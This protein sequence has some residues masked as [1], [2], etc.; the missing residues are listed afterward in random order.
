MGIEIDCKGP[1]L[2]DGVT[3]S[4]IGG[5][6][7]LYSAPFSIRHFRTVGVHLISAGGA[8]QDR[9]GNI[10]PEVS[11]TG[12]DGEWVSLP[13]IAVVALTALLYGDDHPTLGFAYFRLR[14]ERTGGTVGTI[15]AIVNGKL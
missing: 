6:A 4:D 3:N 8:G 2:W 15:R 5:N 12:V 7:A 13:A 14:W 9:A 11:N 10:Y 1:C